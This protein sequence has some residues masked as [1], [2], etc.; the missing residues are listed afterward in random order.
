MTEPLKK[1]RTGTPAP[2]GVK[3]ERLWASDDPDD[4][5]S[6][7]QLYEYDG[8]AWVLLGATKTYEEACN[9]SEALRP[10]ACCGVSTFQTGP[11]GLVPVC[12]KCFNAWENQGMWGEDAE[13]CDHGRKID[14]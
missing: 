2:E 6:K 5:S 1:F 11:G 8:D 7:G 10:C 4:E 14:A 12:S 9:P 3:G 13:P